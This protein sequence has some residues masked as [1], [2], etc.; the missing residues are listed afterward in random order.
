MFKC[1][2]TFLTYRV[3]ICKINKLYFAFVFFYKIRGQYYDLRSKEL[4]TNPQENH[5]H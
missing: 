5:Q 3:A 1:K 2:T 4:V